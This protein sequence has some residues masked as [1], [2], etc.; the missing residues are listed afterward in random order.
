MTLPTQSEERGLSSRQKQ[1]PR[2][3][4]CQTPNQT[5]SK[6]W[7]DTQQRH[8]PKQLNTPKKQLELHWETMRHNQT[9]PENS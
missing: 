4:H 3:E 7:P 8:C 6:V 9:K 5:L 2:E 1:R